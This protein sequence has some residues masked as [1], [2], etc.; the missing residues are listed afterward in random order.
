MTLFQ[1]L[2]MIDA[3]CPLKIV[4]LHNNVLDSVFHKD[5]LKTELL[6]EN[7]FKINVNTV[8]HYINEPNCIVIV[9]RR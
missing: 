8:K 9:L 6:D 2:R 3:D 5:A 1:L 7:I 4:D